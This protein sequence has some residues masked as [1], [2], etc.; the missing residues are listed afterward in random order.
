MADDSDQKPAR[1]QADKDRSRAQSRAVSGKEAAR[2]VSGASPGQ[3]SKPG[4][5]GPGQKQG[6]GGR[7]PTGQGKGGA[8][9]WAAAA[10]RRSPG[11]P[12]PGPR[13]SPTALLTW[14][15]VALVLIVV[16]VLV[17]VKLTGTSSPSASGA[18]AQP[19]PAQIEQQV[20][21]IP[22]SVYNTVGVS[23]PTV[24]VS[25]PHQ[26]KG[27]QP[28]LTFRHKARRLLHG[29][30]VLPVLRGRALG[31]GGHATAGSAH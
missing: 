26:I 17:V 13:R 29:R 31:H 19:V 28:P 12:A 24:A 14:G 27:Q 22:A 9:G 11:G 10:P 20:T 7:G 15:A 2:G 23:S 5:G 3:G 25:P 30:G 21:N 16:V 4:S 1:N 18:T 8:E 6:A